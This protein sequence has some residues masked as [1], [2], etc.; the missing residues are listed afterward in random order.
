MFFPEYWLRLFDICSNWVRSEELGAA[1]TSA[2]PGQQNIHNAAYMSYAWCVILFAACGPNPTAGF[3][4]SELRIAAWE[5]CVLSGFGLWCMF[6][7]VLISVALLAPSNTIPQAPT[8]VI[9]ISFPRRGFSN[10]NKLKCVFSVYAM[11]M[12]E[13]PEVSQRRRVYGVSVGLDLGRKKGF[14]LK[15]QL[16]CISL[17]NKTLYSRWQYAIIIY[18]IWI[19]QLISDPFHC[20]ILV[21]L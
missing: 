3:R 7:P 13:V 6:M 5:N 18:W 4:W 14:A 9:R 8:G 10:W 2:R 11:S 15:I 20:F 19:Y 16:N 21:L 1:F 17:V 12:D